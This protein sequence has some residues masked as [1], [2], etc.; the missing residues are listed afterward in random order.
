[1]GSE[2]Y[3]ATIRY[4]KE[5]TSGPVVSRAKL[6]PFDANLM[7]IVRG[8][9]VSSPVLDLRHT[10]GVTFSRQPLVLLPIET[11]KLEWLRAYEAQKKLA[12][13][14]GT[15]RRHVTSANETYIGNPDHP[16]YLKWSKLSRSRANLYDDSMQAMSVESQTQN[17]DSFQ[18][19]T[20]RSGEEAS[21]R[22]ELI[23]VW[24][25]NQTNRWTQF[26]GAY[27]TEVCMYV[28]RTCMCVY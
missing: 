8:Q 17:H 11:A 4:G 26:D 15:G 18:R 24:Y 10:P 27:I 20:R 23:A 1:M 13:L 9:E 25:N 2:P 28:L 7:K 21:A 12:A 19:Q 5:S 6:V 16:D 14:L 22:I 3:T